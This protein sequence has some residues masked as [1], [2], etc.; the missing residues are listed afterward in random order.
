[1]PTSARSIGMIELPVWAHQ[2]AGTADP[3]RFG[4]Q[5]QGDL[6]EC[7]AV[8]VEELALMYPF[9]LAFQYLAV[10]RF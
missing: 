9:T 5:A 7:G 1:M 10:S 3:D 6:G 4:V 2:E 8:A